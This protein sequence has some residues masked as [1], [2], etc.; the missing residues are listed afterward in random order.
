M[1]G[2]E[3]GKEN[4]GRRLRKGRAGKGGEEM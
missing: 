3:E 1:G 2:R 4:E